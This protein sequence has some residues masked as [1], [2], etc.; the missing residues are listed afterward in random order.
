LLYSLYHASIAV[1]TKPYKAYKMY[2]VRHK[3]EVVALS[4]MHK[5]EGSTYGVIFEKIRQYAC[6]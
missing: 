6:N 5:W 3:I 1:K 4:S 2:K